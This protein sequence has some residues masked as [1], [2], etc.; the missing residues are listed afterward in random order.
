VRVAHVT[1]AFCGGVLTSIATICHTMSG[2]GHD[3][4][5]IYSPR[6]ETPEN[7]KDLFPNTTKFI[8]WSCQREIGFLDLKAFLFLRQIIKGLNCDIVHA[9][10]SKAGALTR[11]VELSSKKPILYSPRGWSYL[12]KDQPWVKRCLFRFIEKLLFCIR[13]N[14]IIVACSNSELELRPVL[15]T[16][17]FCLIK[18]FIA[19]IPE[20]GEK[21]TNKG[22]LLVAGVGRIAPQKNFGAFLEIAQKLQNIEF[23]WVGG[24]HPAGE[25]ELPSN[26]T[27]TG[28]IDRGRATQSIAAS[29][30]LLQTSL[31]EGLPIAALEAMSLGKPIIAMNTPGNVDVVLDGKNGYLCKN[32]EEICEKLKELNSDHLLLKKLGD[33]SKTMFTLYHSIDYGKKKYSELY[34]LCLKKK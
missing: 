34:K 7:F 30:I 20:F 2:E 14:Q 18:N 6:E 5:V 32:V 21:P 31:W 26:L 13:K 23:L 4:V 16:K 1:E 25:K 17:N 8:E 27:V 33:H 15:S 11:L 3:M 10:S 9:H 22:S 28:W 12:Q 29:D 24:P 19:A